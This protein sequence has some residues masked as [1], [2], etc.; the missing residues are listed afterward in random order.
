[1]QL[2]QIII[3]AAL[4]QAVESFAPRGVASEPGGVILG[5]GFLLL[6]GYLMGTLFKDMGL[7][8]L[9]GYLITGV[10]AGP[11]VLGVISPS[12]LPSLR[13]FNGGAT[14]LIPLTAGSELEFRAVKPL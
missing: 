1:M 9:T 4:L 3:L 5:G 8:K 12:M 10:I 14:A 11:A 7:P 13:I 2:V 6:G